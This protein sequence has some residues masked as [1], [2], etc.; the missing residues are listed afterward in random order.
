MHSPLYTCVTPLGFL[1][2][3]SH[4]TCLKAWDLQLPV[5]FPKDFVVGSQQE[6][7]LPN[8]HG[9]QLMAATAPAGIAVTYQF[10]WTL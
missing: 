10:S 7:V 6:L 3:S 5:G 9:I 8:D 4:L 2:S 1:S